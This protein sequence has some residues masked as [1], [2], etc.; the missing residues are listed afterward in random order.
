MFLIRFNRSLV[1]T[2]LAFVVA[3][4]IVGVSFVPS[5]AQNANFIKNGNNGTVSCNTFCGAA[6]AGGQAVWGNQLGSCTGARN[7]SSRENVSCDYKAPSR[8]PR[9]KQLTCGCTDDVFVK[10]GNN[11]TVS[12]STYCNGDVYGDVG[13]RGCVAAYNNATN[14]VESCQSTP[15]LLP[16]GAELT[17]TCRE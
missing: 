2:L 16:N 10:S 15:G 12:C 17:C 9:G 13:T 3:V 8:I 7:E 5:I 1:L 11:G 14:T 4:L 6:R